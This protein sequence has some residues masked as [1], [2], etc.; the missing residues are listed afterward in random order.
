MARRKP[1][2]PKEAV[3][4]RLPEEEVAV[5]KQL[6]AQSFHAD[7]SPMSVNQYCGAVLAAAAQRGMVVQETV[8]YQVTE[9]ASPPAGEKPELAVYTP[10]EETE[11]TG[12]GPA[13]N[14]VRSTRV[15]EK[16]ED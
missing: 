9:T 6:A 15:A 2:Q 7:G 4:L 12:S 13:S 14:P 11:E 10:G 5:L 8:A 3:L 1:A 16:S